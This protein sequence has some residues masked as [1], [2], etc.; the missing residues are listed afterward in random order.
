VVG[1]A[2]LEPTTPG[3]EGRCSIQLSYSPVFFYSL[4]FCVVRAVVQSLVD[5]RPVVIRS[6]VTCVSRQWQSCLRC[7]VEILGSQASLQ[8]ASK[9]E[10][11][12]IPKRFAGY[13]TLSHRTPSG[14]C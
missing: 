11:A 6:G 12:E 9:S 10:V 5:P 4:P 7:P 8:T 14:V 13:V 3:L 1:E 2:G